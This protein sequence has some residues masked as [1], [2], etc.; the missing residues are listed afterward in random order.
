MGL[1]RKQL[2]QGNAAIARGA[3]EAGVHFAAAY[4][5]T[6][7]S[8]IPVEL[9]QYKEVDVQWAANEKVA[10]DEAMGFAISGKRA[11]AVMKY[12]GVNVAA[13][14][15]MVFPYGGTLGGFVLVSCDD[16]GMHSSQN[17]QDN[18]YLAKVAKVPIIEPSDGQEAKDF[19]KDAF[20]ISEQFGLPV[21]FRSTMRICHTKFN[22]GGF[23]ERVEAVPKEYKVDVPTW[24]VPVFA[25]NKRVILD[26]KFT[27]LEE[28]AEVCQLNVI[29]EGDQNFGIITS[30]AAYQ[31]AREIFPDATIFKL[32]MTWPLPKQRLIDFCSRFDQVYVMEE[33]EAFLEEHLRI[34]GVTNL[35]GKE[36]FPSTGELSAAIVDN[37]VNGAE[38]IPDYAKEFP[39]I[40]RPPQLCAG[41]PHRGMYFALKKAKTFVTGDIGCYTLGCLPPLSA[42]HTSFCMGASIGNGFG[43]A[44]G[45]LERVVAI[46]GDSTFIHGGIPSLIDTVYNKANMV[47]V[48]LDNRTTGMTGHQDHPAT[49]YTLKGEKTYE[50]DIEQLV[51]ACGVQFVKKVDPYD[52]A[53]SYQAV[54]EALAFDGPAVLIT[55]RPCA[56]LESEKKKPKTPLMVVQ[57]ECID[58]GAC[59]K[60]GC[61]AINKLGGYTKID[62]NSC[63]GCTMCEQ[64]CKPGAIVT[65]AK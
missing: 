33:Q 55:Y 30:G 13:D 35:I 22:V 51:K 14:S 47:T 17:E 56:L 34:Y 46:I 29:E 8:E 38:F 48:I 63:I 2:M 23:T 61:P 26:Q 50:I 10:F 42:M 5:G 60:L 37:A 39:I 65:T 41:C 43:F 45:G 18:R 52:L 20:E 40:Q 32:G 9:A 24:V 57:E 15:L 19:I 49:G 64:V 7:S 3:Y 28:F 4:P 62:Y 58:C 44:R 54:Q 12:V 59:H 6:P 36:I 27:K 16:P 53:E 25:K 21:M 1:E 11:M 31:Y